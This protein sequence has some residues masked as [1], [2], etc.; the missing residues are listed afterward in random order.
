MG[1]F[2]CQGQQEVK[3]GSEPWSDYLFSEPCFSQAGS[4]LPL[5]VAKRLPVA[6]GKHPISGRK[7]RLPSLLQQ[8]FW[9][10]FWL[11]QIWATC[12]FLNR[13][14]LVSWMEMLVVTPGSCV[15][16]CIY[17]CKSQIRHRN[18]DGGEVVP[19]K[20][21]R[22]K[23]GSDECWAG[24]KQKLYKPHGKPWKGICTLTEC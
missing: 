6:P 19:P 20:E 16:F 21:V 8:K 2:K 12:S 3:A 22:V 7:G 1:S 13:S 4:G 9:D 24:K 10:Y 11:C 18:K 23:V 15:Y 14:A 5:M 17:R